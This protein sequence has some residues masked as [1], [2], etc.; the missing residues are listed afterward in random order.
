MVHSQTFGNAPFLLELACGHNHGAHIAHSPTTAPHKVG[1]TVCTDSIRP[2]QCIPFSFCLL[3]S[4]SH[5]PSIALKHCFPLECQTLLPHSNIEHHHLR[6][7]QTSPPSQMSP[8]PQTLLLP[9]LGIT[10][11]QMLPPPL[12]PLRHS[13]VCLPPLYFTITQTSPPPLLNFAAAQML[14]PSLELHHCSNVASPPL[15]LRHHSNIASPPLNLR[16]RSNVA[17]LL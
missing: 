8:P 5:S 10:A 3:S 9:P 15:R 12:K 11:A 14:P 16:H 1:S 2:F 13:N 4:T 6:K 17:P 7:H